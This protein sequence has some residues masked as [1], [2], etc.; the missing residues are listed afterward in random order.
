M[1]S[2]LQ[3]RQVK[4]CV[5]LDCDF[6]VVLQPE[7]FGHLPQHIAPEATLAEVGRTDYH[8]ERPPPRTVLERSHVLVYLGK[9]PRFSQRLPG[10]SGCFF[11]PHMRAHL[12]LLLVTDYIEN[13]S[14][15]STVP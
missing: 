6:Q 8:Q 1:L 4:V 11:Y 13:I 15:T 10:C 2:D 5:F 14:P 12:R 9:R 3:T 7:L